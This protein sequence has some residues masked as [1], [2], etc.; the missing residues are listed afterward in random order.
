LFLVRLIPNQAYL[1]IKIHQLQPLHH[2]KTNQLFKT[3][4]QFFKD[5][6]F[7]GYKFDIRIIK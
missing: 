3:N 1:R 7:T 6:T 4:R 5:P 2:L